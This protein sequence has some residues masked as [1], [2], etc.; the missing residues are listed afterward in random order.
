MMP[1][2]AINA[3]ASIKIA[4]TPATFELEM[5]RR[6]ELT[7]KISRSR[8]A[9]NV[10]LS[11]TYPTAS[12]AM[13]AGMRSFT[14]RKAFAAPVISPMARTAG[15]AN[16]RPESVP[17]DKIKVIKADTVMTPGMERS[18]L[19]L[20]LAITNI[21]PMATIT[22]KEAEVATPERLFRLK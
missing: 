10:A 18:I 22:R 21:W 15:S 16:S 6:R 17:L 9:I 3:T 2:A 1:A 11:R 12:V 8:L 20:P 7:V 4:G 19:P 5:P 13:I 14:T